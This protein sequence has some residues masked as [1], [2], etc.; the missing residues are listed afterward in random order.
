ALFRVSSPQVN[1]QR[2]ELRGLRAPVCEGHFDGEP[3]VPGAV[4]IEDIVLS[5]IA[6]SFSDLKTPRRLLRV[7]FPEAIPHGAEVHVSLC[8]RGDRVD[9]EVHIGASP[10]ATGT[11]EYRS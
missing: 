5:N 11:V 6:R 1:E 4:V 2:V 8:R 10:R 9:F 7:R 3:I